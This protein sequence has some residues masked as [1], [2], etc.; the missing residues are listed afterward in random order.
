MFP[1]FSFLVKF[2]NTDE[3]SWS[4]LPLRHGVGVQRNNCDF[5]I[6]KIMHPSASDTFCVP[7]LFLYVS[8]LFSSF[9]TDKLSS[10]FSTLNREIVRNG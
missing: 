2:Q 9:Q 1:P 7:P 6:H 5:K 4:A 10:L 3:I 8:M